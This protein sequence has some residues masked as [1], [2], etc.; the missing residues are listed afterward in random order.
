MTFEGRK[1][2]GQGLPKPGGMSEVQ[3]VAVTRFW[4]RFWAI[5]IGRLQKGLAV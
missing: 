2:W 1:R 4:P 5:E 3:M